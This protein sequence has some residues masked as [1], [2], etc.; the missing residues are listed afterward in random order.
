MAAKTYNLKVTRGNGV[1]DTLSFT[2][3]DTIGRYKIKAT[4]SNGSVIE[5]EGREIIVNGKENSYNL[6]FKLSDGSTIDA[7]IITTPVVSIPSF[8]DISGYMLARVCAYDD[9]RNYFRV[10]DRKTIQLKTGEEITVVIL[11]FYHDN[12]G[13]G[14]KAPMTIG[15]EN[16]LATTYRMNEIPTTE[17]GWRD[18][19]MRTSTLQKIFSDFP[20]DWQNAIK[21]VIKYTVLGNGNESVEMTSDKLFLYAGVEIDGSNYAGYVNEGEQYE[22]WK[23]VRDGTLNGPRIKYLS[24]GSGSVARWWYR[25]PRL[26]SPYNYFTGIGFNGNR[27]SDFASEPL[28]VCFCFCV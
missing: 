2:I 5:N 22:Y 19:E 14:A 10:G 27:M 28:G 24:N 9:P 21:E 4:L 12:L 13:F 6:K 25:S 1:Q 3:P 23:T 18:S 26:N 7:G 11:G 8:A 15:M 16:L 20:D 17:G